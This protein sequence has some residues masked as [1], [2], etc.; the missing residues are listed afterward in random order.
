MPAIRRWTKVR[1]DQA[2][3]ADGSVS[4][5]R[6]IM[7]SV[8]GTPTVNLI[9]S[10]HEAAVIAN[11]EVERFELP[12]AFFADN[13]CLNGILGLP[14][15]DTVLLQANAPD[16]QQL[17]IQHKVTLRDENGVAVVPAPQDIHFAFVVPERAFEDIETVRAA[18]ARGLLS[19]R[20]AACLLMVDFPNPVFSD[21]R[22]QLL[23]H[24]PETATIVDGASTFSEEFAKAINNSSAVDTPGTPEHEFSQHW[25]A[26]DGWPDHLGG[27]LTDYYQALGARLQSTAG[28]A[29]IFRVAEARREQVRAMPIHENPLLFATP[30]PPLRES[31]AMQPDAS[32]REV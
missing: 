10:E 23:A 16:Y 19:E 6:Q 14:A 13:E 4:G 31:L 32:V 20:L 1:F 27:L 25:A 15:P 24:V 18:I 11:G 17:L 3:G 21:R 5:V 28:L 12:P 30:D 26:G 22:E 2:I 7:A 29:D 9:S 8:L